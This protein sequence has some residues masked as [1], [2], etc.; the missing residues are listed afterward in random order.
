[1]PFLADHEGNRPI[2]KVIRQECRGGRIEGE[3]RLVSTKR[4]GASL[5]LQEL[6]A[7]C[8]RDGISPGIFGLRRGLGGRPRCMP[9]K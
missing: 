8:V 2:G 4:N 5:Y 1:M 9:V 6:S 7:G 3:A